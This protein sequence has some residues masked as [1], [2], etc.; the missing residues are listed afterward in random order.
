MTSTGRPV[1]WGILATGGIAADFAQD[2]THVPDADALAVGSRSPEAAERFAARHGIERAYGSWAELAADADL[3]AVYVATP[4]AAHF[5]AVGAC[6]AAG[7]AVLC[8]KPFTVSAR[9]AERLVGMAR[10]HEAFLMEAMWMRTN[11][12]IRRIVELVADG[13]IGELRAVHA[14]FSLPGPFAADHRLRDPFL[15]GGGLLD[16]GVYPVSLAHLLLG[17]PESVQAA[18]RLTPE[19]VDGNTGLLL[20]Y[21]S[22]AVALLSCGI[23]SAGPCVATISGTS[24]RITVGA[25]FFRPDRF[26][27]QRLGAAPEEVSLPFAGLG[28]VHEIEEAGRCLRAGRLESPLVPWQSSLEVMRILDS[29]RTQ[30]GVRYPSEETDPVTPGDLMGAAG[31]A[32]PDFTKAGDPT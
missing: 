32:S 6:L 2:V 10:E 24:G 9:Q 30:I 19:G 16:L 18:A 29:V 21:G 11:P 27:L 20:K 17:V 26:V 25:P 22:G 31:S 15:G 1:R 23:E 5:A 28:Y 8:E 3:D 13:A 12:A 4:P 14:D 7:K